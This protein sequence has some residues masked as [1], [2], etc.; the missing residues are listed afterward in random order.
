MS[1]I[2]PSREEIYMAIARVMAERSVCKRLS[3]GVVA[4]K[5]RRI[6][7]TGY[8]GPLTPVKDAKC[9]CIGDQPCQASIH[10]EANL[11]AFAAKHGINLSGSTIYTS[12]SP[13]VKCQELLI[14]S[15]VSEIIYGYD[16]RD[17]NKDLLDLTG[18]TYRKYEGRTIQISFNDR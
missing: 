9:S 1:E 12:H 2:R 11:V 18:V 10:A 6:I 3:V 8:N 17:L 4:V 5:D 14:Q 16:Y 13:C 15:G 7:A